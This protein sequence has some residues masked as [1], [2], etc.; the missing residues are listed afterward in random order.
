MQFTHVWSLIKT[1]LPVWGPLFW[2][3][4]SGFIGALGVHLLTQ[5]RERE[6]WIL[7]CKKQEFK[8]LMSALTESYVWTIR[9]RGPSDEEMQKSHAEARANALRVFRDRLYISDDL[10]LEPFATQ[11][12]HTSTLYMDLRIVRRDYEEIRTAIISA[13]NKAV[14][15]TTM[16]RLQFWKR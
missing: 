9:L 6:K 1:T 8:E 2:A 3:I 14:P 12:D 4:I 10:P 13:A 16:Q 7:D 15:K 11:W 5:S